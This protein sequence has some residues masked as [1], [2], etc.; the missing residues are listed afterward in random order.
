ME[1]EIGTEGNEDPGKSN[2]DVLT[3]L[4][5][6]IEDNFHN[7]SLG[8]QNSTWKNQKRH[9]LI[10]EMLI[11]DV[12]QRRPQLI[13]S[14]R[15]NACPTWI[16]HKFQNQRFGIRRVRAAGTPT[17]GCQGCNR[18]SAGTGGSV[19]AA[20]QANS[21]AAKL[22][23][24]LNAD[25]SALAQQWFAKRP[26]PASMGFTL[27]V[28]KRFSPERCTCQSNF[29]ASQAVTAGL[30]DPKRLVVLRPASVAVSGGTSCI[31][32]LVEGWSNFSCCGFCSCCQR[33]R[34]RHLVSRF[35]GGTG[36]GRT[37]DDTR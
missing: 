5:S 19:L 10:A 8:E 33:Q 1:R 15:P 31:P 7:L 14:A 20:A 22:V 29:A 28:R 3:R 21:S 9:V 34:E 24:I 13:C 23:A 25:A 12:S 35:L 4:S 17:S 30:Q 26:M 16:S 11:E 37:E 27:R 2:N 36:A 6:N 32:S 18:V